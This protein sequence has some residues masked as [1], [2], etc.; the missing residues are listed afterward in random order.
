MDGD[1]LELGRRTKKLKDGLRRAGVK[2]THQRLVI[3]HE[4]AKSSDH[5]D[6]EKIYKGVR[7][8]IPT[9]SLDTVY[10]TLWLL[11]DLGL[12]ETLSPPRYKTRFE[13]NLSAHH[14]FVCMKCGMTRDFD[15]DDFNR[16]K[17]PD[18][19]KAMGSVDKVQVE[20]KGLCPKCFKERPKKK[21]NIIKRRIRHE[22]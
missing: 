18:S 8:S 16:L 1:P 20:A 9:V 10:R 6:A 5:P 17:L 3:F 19:V 4:V 15:S 2:A 12:V 11:V 7:R 22:K 21:Q 13:A 14:H